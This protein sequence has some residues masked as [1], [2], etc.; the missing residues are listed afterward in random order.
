[1]EIPEN[2]LED[3]G[4]HQGTVLGGF[5]KRQGTFLGALGKLNGGSFCEINL[6]KRSNVSFFLYFCRKHQGTVLR[7][8]ETLR[9]VLEG[10]WEIPGNGLW[11]L[12]ETS[13][14]FLGTLGNRYG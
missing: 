8:Q 4:K 6:K 3:F 7:F 1:M 5:G 9:N 11:E 2:G 14:I 12:R 13:G 10:L